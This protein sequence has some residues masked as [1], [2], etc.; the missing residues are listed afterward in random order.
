M[1]PIQELWRH[2]VSIYGFALFLFSFEFAE[3]VAPLASVYVA[4]LGQE[5]ECWQRD[6]RDKK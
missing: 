6:E 1:K 2:R 5:L 3:I 4:L